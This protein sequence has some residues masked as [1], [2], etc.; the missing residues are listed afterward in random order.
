MLK[1]TLIVMLCCALCLSS[2]SVSASSIYE[3]VQTASGYTYSETRNGHISLLPTQLVNLIYGTGL[4]LGFEGTQEGMNAK[5]YILPPAD[6]STPLKKIH[7]TLEND[8]YTL[9]LEDTISLNEDG[10][11]TID[12][13]SD[14]LRLCEI[15]STSASYTLTL[16]D[17]EGLNVEVSPL[18]TQQQLLV[19]LQKTFDAHFML[20]D[21]TLLPDCYLLTP[22]APR[23]ESEQE[24]STL[25]AETLLLGKWQGTVFLVS[26]M[27]L[28]FQSDGICTSTIND[29]TVNYTWQLTDDAL[30]MEQDGHITEGTFDGNEILLNMGAEMVPFIRESDLPNA[31]QIFATPTKCRYFSENQN[32]PQPN[33]FSDQ[34]TSKFIAYSVNGQSFGNK[35]LYSL[36]V[37]NDEKIPHHMRYL[38]TIESFGFQIVQINDSFY[39]ICEDGNIIAKVVFTNT[40]AME[41]S[42]PPFW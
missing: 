29:S 42:F 23:L 38:K 19:L 11:Y 28:D 40:Y 17:L 1:K 33:S 4:Y 16:V 22:E 2:I 20:N 31:D 35:Y 27:T 30:I 37:L 18:P 21:L 8:T 6:F 10:F 5:L 26:T 7:I 41:I 34:Y 14:I 12:I 39:E 24:E 9:Q 36:S 3:N 13:K 32:L 15:I 25:P